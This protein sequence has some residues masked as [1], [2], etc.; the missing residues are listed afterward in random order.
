ME[1]KLG[2]FQ[3]SFPDCRIDFGEVL[4]SQLNK[5]PEKVWAFY[6]LIITKQIKNILFCIFKMHKIYLMKAQNLGNWEIQKLSILSEYGRGDID[7]HRCRKR[8]R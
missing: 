4:Y 5:N 7:Y 2:T 8:K 6:L 3:K 1:T